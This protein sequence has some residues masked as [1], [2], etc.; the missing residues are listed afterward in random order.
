MIYEL[1]K[2]E[3]IARKIIHRWNS[4]G[5][6]HEILAIAIP[7][8]LSS[9]AWSILMFVD[10]LFLAWFSEDAITASVPAGLVQFTLVSLFLGT[11]M[12]ANTFVAQYFGSGQNEKVGEAVWQGIYFSFSAMIVIFLMIPLADSM[13]KLV[14]HAGHIQILEHQYFVILCY[15][16]FFPVASAAISSFFSGLGKTWT[17]MWVNLSGTIVNIILD[18][19]LIFGKFG[20][21]R[22]GIQGAAIA[23]VIGMAFTFFLFFTLFL[24]SRYRFEFGT[25]KGRFFNLEL[26]KRLIIFGIP[27]GVQFALDMFGFT[28]FLLFIGRYGVTELAA[29]NI[30]FS[31]NNFAFMPLI[32]LGIAVSIRVGQDLGNNDSQSANYSVWSA[33]HIGL[34]YTGL[35]SVLF[36]LF[37]IFFLTP[38]GKNFDPVRFSEITAYGST[39]LRFV[40]L[41]F[42]FDTANMIFSAAIKGAGDTKF[43]MKTIILL[44]TTLLIL[45]AYLVV[46]VFN[47]HLF[48]AWGCMSVYILVTALVFFARFKQGKWKSMLVIERAESF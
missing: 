48:Y 16:G 10:R 24:N 23:S 8:I 3:M 22:L 34:V 47:L 1:R 20:F 2:R 12:Y 44:S 28:V 15:G 14:G 29:S 46:D 43:V 27:N 21:P 19:I 36:F 11:A 26:F 37:P 33:F 13:F 4:P 9:S 30:T 45:P 39:L 35:L 31:I 7:L 25:W 17:V 18:Y 32:G 38:F 42:V 40:A 6:Y 41:Y 5:G